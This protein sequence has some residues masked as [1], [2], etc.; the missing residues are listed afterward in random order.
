MHYGNHLNSY[1][2][3]A[4]FML[5]GGY[6]REVPVLLIK[7]LRLLRLKIEINCEVRM[8]DLGFDLLRTWALTLSSLSMFIALITGTV[9][10]KTG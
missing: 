7:K 1:K 6:I 5:V 2:I 9:N 8:F 10:I 4:V 3:I